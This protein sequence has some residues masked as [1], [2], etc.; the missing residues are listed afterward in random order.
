V[1][2]ALHLQRH[3][4]VPERRARSAD[5]TRRPS[6]RV[7]TRK[8][9]SASAISGTTFERIPPR[10]T[11]TLTVTPRSSSVRASASRHR[12]ASST[13]AF[14]PLSKSAPACAAR[15]CARSVTEPEPFLRVLTAPPGHAGSNPSTAADDFMADSMRAR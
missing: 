5:A 12:R 11:P 1:Q 14:L 8:S 10:I 3:A 15:P 4:G 2:A 9:T 7:R 13:I 6:S